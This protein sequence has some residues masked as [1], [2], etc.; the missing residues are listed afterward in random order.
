[1]KAWGFLICSSAASMHASL[2]HAQSSV[3]LTGQVDQWIGSKELPGQERAWGLYGGGMQTSWWGLR[4]QED[5]GG[6]TK[7]VFSLEGLYSAN[8]VVE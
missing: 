1:M 7:A 4:G 5:L 3:T 2:A 6:G 8:N